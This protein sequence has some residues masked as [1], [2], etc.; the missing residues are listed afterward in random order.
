MSDRP[1][2][3]TA[4]PAGGAPEGRS[5]V[6]GIFRLARFRSDGLAEFTP[7]RQAFLNSLAPLI[8]FPLVGWLLMMMGGGGA[9]A[10]TDLLVTIV[11]LL[12]PPVISASLARLW[13][14]EPAWLRYAVAF[15]WCQ[16]A[17]PLAAVVVLL[18]MGMMTRLG[19]T[20]VQA[21]IGSLFAIAGYGLALHWFLARHGLALSGG[22]AVLFVVLLNVGTVALVVAPRLVVESVQ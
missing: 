3:G 21:A 13:G 20:E 4:G 12:A 10:L 22:Q 14:R 8:A 19:L 6:R 17:V 1:P 7:T 18:V 9:A 2:R 15:N 5:V 16:W 11:A